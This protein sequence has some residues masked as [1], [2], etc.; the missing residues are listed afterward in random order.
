MADPSSYRLLFRTPV[1]SY[2]GLGVAGL[3]DRIV[4][5]GA[6]GLPVIPGSTVKGRLRFFAER[7]LSA[8]GAPPDLRL[9]AS[10]APA[11]KHLDTACTACRLFGNS[12]IP[13]LLRVGAASLEE[14]WAP[15]LR[16]LLLADPNPVVHA[17]AEIRPGIALS[18]T[19]RTALGDHLFLDETVPASLSFAGTLRFGGEIRAEEMEFLVA[20]ASLVDALGARKAA[21]R[22]SLDGGIRIEAGSR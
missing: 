20:A 4:V 18:R 11:C 6:D 3:V 16:T 15:L 21:G 17:D 12:A 2:T 9:H 5:R 7:L 1:G 14:P 22:G 8:G 13:A 10:G 19:R